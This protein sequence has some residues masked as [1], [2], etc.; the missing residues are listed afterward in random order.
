MGKG[1]AAR[2]LR[3]ARSEGQSNILSFAMW[4]SGEGQE[5][6]DPSR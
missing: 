4:A 3:A 6:N 5:G 2:R 1:M